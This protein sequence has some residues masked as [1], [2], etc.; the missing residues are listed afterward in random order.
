MAFLHGAGDF[1]V[2]GATYPQAEGVCRSLT[3]QN[4]AYTQVTHLS[5]YSS[6]PLS[7]L[8]TLPLSG[9]HSHPLLKQRS[10]KHF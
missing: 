3:Q 5:I 10:A 4:L 9:F 2:D 6:S 1:H 7:I 8:Q